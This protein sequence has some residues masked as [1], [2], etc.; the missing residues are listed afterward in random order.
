M[1]VSAENCYR[2]A[3]MLSGL[4]QVEAAD[5]LAVGMRT[6]S[7]YENGISAVPDDVALAMSRVYNRPE[8]RVEHLR[9]N[10]VF[11]DLMGDVDVKND[12][13]SQVLKMYKEVNDV[14]KCF[15]QVVDDTITKK[16]L[17]RQMFD[18]CKEACQALMSLFAGTKKGTADNS[19]TVQKRA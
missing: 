2:R 15:P 11:M 19:S 4:K 6:L 12:M 17:S 5:A 13:S 8:L 14:V 3:R 9:N 18:E 16:S 7:D 10:P 1:Q